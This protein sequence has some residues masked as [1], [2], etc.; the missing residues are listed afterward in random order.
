MLIR[1]FFYGHLLLVF[2]HKTI[3]SINSLYDQELTY[4]AIFH[5]R[6]SASPFLQNT[7]VS[8]VHI[9]LM[10]HFDS[11]INSC[12]NKAYSLM[13]LSLRNESSE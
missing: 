3:T 2:K 5:L 7:K 8:N 11:F 1:E 12:L 13:L 9:V 10:S 6:V 4:F